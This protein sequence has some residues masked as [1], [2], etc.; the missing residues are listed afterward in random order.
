[1]Q[2]AAMNP[3]SSSRSEMRRRAWGSRSGFFSLLTREH[4]VM[5]RRAGTSSRSRGRWSPAAAARPASIRADSPSAPTPSVVALEALAGPPRSSTI[6]PSYTTRTDLTAVM[7]LSGMFSSIGYPASAIHLG[8]RSGRISSVTL[9]Y[10]HSMCMP[11]ATCASSSMGRRRRPS[12]SSSSPPPPP[13]CSC[14]AA[15]APLC[16]PPD[17][18]PPCVSN[19]TPLL[20]PGCAASPSSF[21]PARG[22]GGPP[23]AAESS[24]WASRWSGWMGWTS[25]GYRRRGGRWNL[26]RRGRCSGPDCTT[27]SMGMSSGRVPALFLT[28]RSS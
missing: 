13:P 23:L 8:G 9:P 27:L 3:V 22:S 5:R 28:M 4:H 25:T 20:Y 19:V 16:S 26:C 15:G 2:A 21:L 17:G 11:A 12:A 10:V 1:M 6:R 14:S 18:L 7:Y 24:R